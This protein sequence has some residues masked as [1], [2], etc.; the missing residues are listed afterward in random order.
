[1]MFHNNKSKPVSRWWFKISCKYEKEKLY[2]PQTYNRFE[3]FFS[4]Y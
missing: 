2:M 3:D 1:M 4:K